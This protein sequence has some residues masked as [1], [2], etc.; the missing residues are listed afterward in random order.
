MKAL[1]II[2]LVFACLKSVAYAY[3]GQ[4][5]NSILL[6]GAWEFA[7]G[8]GNESVES[9][10]EQTRLEWQKVNLPGPFMKWNQDAGELPLLNRK[11]RRGFLVKL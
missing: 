6:N 11:F 10:K 7:L 8:D 2:I 3:E 1:I 4:R 9:I 5:G